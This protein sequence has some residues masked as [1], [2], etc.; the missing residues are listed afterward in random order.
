MYFSDHIIKFIKESRLHDY[1]KKV[2]GVLSSGLGQSNFPSNLKT[3]SKA[4]ILT[5]NYSVSIKTNSPQVYTHEMTQSIA[6]CVFYIH[7]SLIYMHALA[8]L[9]DND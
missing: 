4:I 6:C 9:V 7:F 8:T 3:S 2:S 1:K 5:N